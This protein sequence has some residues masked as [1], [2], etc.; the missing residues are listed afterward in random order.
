MSPA[1]ELLLWWTWIGFQG[2]GLGSNRCCCPWQPLLLFHT[3]CPLPLTLP[4]TTG[5][6]KRPLSLPAHL[7]GLLCSFFCTGSLGTQW[8]SVACLPL[9]LLSPRLDLLLG[10]AARGEVAGQA[11]GSAHHPPQRSVPWTMPS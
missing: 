9:H 7:G 3:I 6:A 4:K 10:R 11:V 2:E 5:P 8:A 1:S